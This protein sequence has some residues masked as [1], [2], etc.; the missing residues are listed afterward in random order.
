M[1]DPIKV[2]DPKSGEEFTF[3]APAWV[4]EQVRDGV[5]T[6]KPPAAPVETKQQDEDFSWL[7]HLDM[8]QLIKVAT[9]QRM[10]GVHFYKDEDKLREKIIQ[11]M[12]AE[13]D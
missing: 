13:Q 7:D 4:E 6:Y 12:K 1:S 8:D 2:Y 10:R 5:Y 9:E 3:F 11:K